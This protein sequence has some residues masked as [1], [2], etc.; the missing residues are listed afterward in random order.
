MMR[1][2][3]LGATMAI[4]AGC[5]HPAG[6]G[7]GEPIR[8][9]AP[10]AVQRLIVTPTG[11]VRATDSLGWTHQMA[12]ARAAGRQLDSS[13][14]VALEARG[15]ASRWILPAELT[16]VFERNRTY[17]TDPYQLAVEQ[18]RSAA[19]KVGARY[20]EPLS[21][22]LRTMIALHEDARFVLVPADLHFE[23]DGAGGRAVVRLVLLD[24]RFAEARW[25]GDVSGVSA[26]TPVLA[27]SSAADRVADLFVAP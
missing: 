18:V 21:S 26:Q 5:H 10:F 23:R 2:A 27:L 8:P 17:A 7:S 9:L 15:L 19:F 4:V 22:Q 14:V 24:P 11:H 20:G 13:I 12:G 1:L 6:D 25:V 16:R 3:M